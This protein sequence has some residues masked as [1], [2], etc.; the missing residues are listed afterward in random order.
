MLLTDLQELRRTHADLTLELC[1]C[2]LH[3]RLV[4]TRTINFNAIPKLDAYRLLVP[5]PLVIDANLICNFWRVC[6]PILEPQEVVHVQG[7]CQKQIDQL[8]FTRA[9]RLIHAIYAITQACIILRLQAA[10]LFPC[11]AT[12]RHATPYN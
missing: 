5:S 4:N 9:R 7:V 1:G 3:P 2:P 10:T 8:C 12:I 11:T 6:I